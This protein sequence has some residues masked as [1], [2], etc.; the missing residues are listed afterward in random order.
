MLHNDLISYYERIFAFKQYH[1]WN[2]SEIEN[3]LPWELDV[4]TSL[5]SNYLETMEMKRKQSIL[6]QQAL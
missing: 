2:I 1:K 4:M 5:L 3:L 6:D